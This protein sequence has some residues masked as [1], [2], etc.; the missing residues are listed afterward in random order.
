MSAAAFVNA[1]Q[2]ALDTLGS[3]ASLDAKTFESVINPSQKETVMA[4]LNAWKPP[5]GTAG[6][7][8]MGAAVQPAPDR[9]WKATV[10]KLTYDAVCNNKAGVCTSFALAAAYYMTASQ[11]TGPLVEVVAI[12]NHVYVVVGREGGYAD[13]WALPPKSS[14]GSGCIVVDV[15]LAAMG[16]KSVWKASEFPDWA[17]KGAH[18]IM[19]RDPS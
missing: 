8:N 11:T 15:W 10:L 1:S 19:K 6:T 4:R 2:S 17:T 7:G 18:L 13:G 16:W 12:K 9:S 3:Y 5:T 14:W